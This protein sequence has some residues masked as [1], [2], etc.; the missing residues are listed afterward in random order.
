M[1]VVLALG[2]RTAGIAQ[3]ADR[4][5]SSITSVPDPASAVTAPI[6]AELNGLKTEVARLSAADQQM[7]ATIASM[8][9][10]QRELQQRLTSASAA[11]HLFSDPKLLQLH[12]VPG[13][14]TPTTGSTARS[15]TTG[16]R[17]TASAAP[18]RGE[19][20]RLPAPRP[21]NAPLVLAPSN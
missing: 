17:P 2:W 15:T 19:T 14:R 13:K 7:A 1:G 18:V 21:G 9:A 6:L 3:Q 12:L 20:R 10:Q 5:W 16:F 11:T 4:L 8:Q